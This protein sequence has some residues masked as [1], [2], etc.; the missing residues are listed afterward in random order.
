MRGISI[1]VYDTDD[2]VECHICVTVMSDRIA[3]AL[4]PPS[5]RV[6][7]P[8][9]GIRSSSRHSPSPSGPTSEILAPQT[10]DT[11]V[12]APLLDYRGLDLIVFAHPRQPL[13]IEP[14]G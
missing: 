1:R 12:L 5:C 7:S 8:I 6:S 14:C 11:V 9:E 13:S 3:K 10:A 4:M 2:I